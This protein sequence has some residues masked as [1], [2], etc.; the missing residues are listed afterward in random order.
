MNTLQSKAAD[1]S[2]TADW[3]S[4]VS[5]IQKTKQLVINLAVSK[6]K[7]YDSSNLSFSSKSSKNYLAAA[8][9][10]NLANLSRVLSATNFSSQ[11]WFTDFSATTALAHFQNAGAFDSS[12]VGMLGERRP[13]YFG[14]D[15]NRRRKDPV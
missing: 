15:S 4:R 10:A 11:M 13:S 2:N 3:S 5:R 12:N 1:N 9:A 6:F 7:S 14:N 8:A